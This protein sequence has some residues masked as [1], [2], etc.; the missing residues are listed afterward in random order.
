MS[1]V[2]EQMQ[3]WGGTFG[4][5]YTDRNA[6]DVDQMEILYKER[7][8]LT[9]TEINR[10]FFSNLD[11]S[12]RILEVGCNI[13][14][15]LLC[16]QRMGFRNL[17]GIEIQSYAVEVAKGGTRDINIIKGSALDIPFKDRFFDLVFTSAVLIHIKPGDLPQVMTEIHRCTNEYIWGMEYYADTVTKLNY[18]GH[19]EPLW[20]DNFARIYLDLFPHLK[21]VKEEHFN[22]PDSDNKDTMFLLSKLP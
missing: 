7:F 9:R 19:D 2:T 15:Q 4:R 1:E 10:Q 20:K 12:M 14:N 22:Y 3:E 13:G 8:G 21:L 11:P 5:A 16:L 6:S 17:Y 18:R